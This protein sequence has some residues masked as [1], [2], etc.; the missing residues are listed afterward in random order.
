MEQA[1]CLSCGLHWQRSRENDQGSVLTAA[2]GVEI[3]FN[4]GS[5]QSLRQ[6]SAARS[7]RY[8]PG[9]L[10]EDAGRAGGFGAKPRPWQG[11]HGQSREGAESCKPQALL[12]GNHPVLV[13]EDAPGTAAGSGVRGGIR[14]APLTPIPPRGDL[15]AASR[16]RL[17]D[18]LLAL[19]IPSSTI[20]GESRLLQGNAISADLSELSSGRACLGACR[21]LFLPTPAPSISKRRRT[22]RAASP[23]ALETVKDLGSPDLPHL[24]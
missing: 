15:G 14:P 7:E 20:A 5:E 16:Q 3:G 2:W 12:S 18:K 24:L 23:G 4:D 8:L 11:A 13:P 21:S 17:G 9:W 19:E 1:A 10:R 22:G 6:L